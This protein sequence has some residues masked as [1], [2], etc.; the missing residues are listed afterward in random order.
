MSKLAIS[1]EPIL[2]FGAIV[3]ILQVVNTV[4]NGGEVTQTAINSVIVALGA[5]FGRQSVTPVAKD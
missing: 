5:L 1:K 3:I 2:W 4:I